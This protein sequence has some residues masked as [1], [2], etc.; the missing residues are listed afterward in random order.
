MDRF[1][2]CPAEEKILLI[3]TDSCPTELTCFALGLDEKS[4]H[5]DIDANV[6]RSLE[7]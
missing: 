7:G 4:S 3:C 6:I 5:A 1:N 2:I